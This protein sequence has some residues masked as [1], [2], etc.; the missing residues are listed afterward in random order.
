MQWQLEF[1]QSKPFLQISWI[2]DPSREAY[3][4]GK[5]FVGI[6]GG[7]LIFSTVPYGDSK[8]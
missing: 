8:S 2:F 1:L 7:Y 3:V 4:K 5:Y 6:G